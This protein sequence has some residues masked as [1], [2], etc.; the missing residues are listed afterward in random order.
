MKRLEE[1]QEVEV[2]L[3]VEEKEYTYK[4]EYGG[5]LGGISFPSE[6]EKVADQP[7]ERGKKLAELIF[8][9]LEGQDIEFPVDLTDSSSWK[10]HKIVD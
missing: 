9:F 4:L 8:R 2:K 7:V 5:W 6:L 10:P 3:L 1:S